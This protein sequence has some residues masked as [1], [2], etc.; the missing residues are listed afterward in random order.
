MI[1]FYGPKL[2]SVDSLSFKCSA[3]TFSPLSSSEYGDPN[4]GISTQNCSCLNRPGFCRQ[5]SAV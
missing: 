1:Y 2:R 3:A 5:S 4:S